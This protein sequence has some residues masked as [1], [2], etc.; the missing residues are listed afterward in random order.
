M[1]G[2][3]FGR[4]KATLSSWRSGIDLGSGRR[5]YPV[6]SQTMVNLVAWMR[7]PL[8]ILNDMVRRGGRW[9]V[10]CQF[11]PAIHHY[12][13]LTFKTVVFISIRRD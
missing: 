4:S 9:R 11:D 5:I 1:E 7:E 8:L 2:A 10:H 6:L 13:R 12:S 3:T